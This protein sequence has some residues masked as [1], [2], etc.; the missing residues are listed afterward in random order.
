MENRIKSIC[1][2]KPIA[3]QNI[4]LIKAHPNYLLISE[5]WVC[6][7]IFP[8][9]SNIWDNIPSKNRMKRT[10]ACN[11]LTKSYTEAT[12]SVLHIVIYV[13]VAW[14]RANVG[15]GK[16]ITHASNEAAAAI[17]RKNMCLWTKLCWTLYIISQGSTENQL[18][19][20]NSLLKYHDY[21]YNYNYNYNSGKN[22]A[23]SLSHYQKLCLSYGISQ[24]VSQSV[25]QSVGRSVGR[26]VGRSVGRSVSQS[27]CW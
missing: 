21:N 22:Q 25:G 2:I 9:T 17:V 8:T 24:S 23:C 16:F 3:I 19:W 15:N 27:V 13:I 20:V 14:R 1:A 5:K 12:M 18:C 11:V 26:L 6:R 10:F 7:Y 4:S